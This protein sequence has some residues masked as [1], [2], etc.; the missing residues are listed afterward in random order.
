MRLLGENRHVFFF[1]C[2]VHGQERY[3]HITYIIHIIHIIL[4]NTLHLNLT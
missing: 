3:R 1:Q 4:I 2:F